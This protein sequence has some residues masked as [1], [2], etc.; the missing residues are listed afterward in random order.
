MYHRQSVSDI[1]SRP[2]GIDKERVSTEWIVDEGYRLMNRC[3]VA[4][5]SYLFEKKG[6]IAVKPIAPQGTF[7]HL[8]DISLEHGAEDVKIL[9]DEGEGEVWEVYLPPGELSGLNRVL[10]K[11]HLDQYEIQS[12]ELAWVPNEPLEPGEDGEM[13]EERAEGIMKTVELL[14]EE[15]DVLQVWTNLA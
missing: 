9:E 5:V 7:D 15:G 13:S 12:S 6:V 2:G 11:D 10:T 3:R 1:C 4:P 8:F 14:E